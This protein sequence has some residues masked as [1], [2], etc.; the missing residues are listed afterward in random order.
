MNLVKKKAQLSGH[1][2]YF[3]V[4]LGSQ[5][6]G[7]IGPRLASAQWRQASIQ[8]VRGP[9]GWVRPCCGLYKEKYSAL[10]LWTVK[11]VLQE[12]HHW[13]C[14]LI[15]TGFGSCWC[16]SFDCRIDGNH[17]NG[18]VHMALKRKEAETIKSA[19]KP[20]NTHV[21]IPRF[22]H[23]FSTAQQN[24]VRSSTYDCL[25]AVYVQSTLQ[26][27]ISRWFTV[28]RRDGKKSPGFD[29]GIFSPVGLT[30]RQLFDT[31]K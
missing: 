30:L 21:V 5:Q 4:V 8:I 31:T 6:K 26:Q 11:S 17:V 19:S 27:C 2:D 1:K 13:W 16:P 22:V 28:M 3:E 29:H 9:E 7:S 10:F 18:S 23:T 24:P 12:L 14:C 15:W 20:S 25:W